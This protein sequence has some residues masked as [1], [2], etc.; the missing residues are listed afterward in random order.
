MKRQQQEQL[1][2]NPEPGIQNQEP[3]ECLGQTFDSD[4]ARREHFLK[5]LAESNR[6]RLKKLLG[7]VPR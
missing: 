5:L 1:A 7:D 3:V 2:F 6:S 4:E